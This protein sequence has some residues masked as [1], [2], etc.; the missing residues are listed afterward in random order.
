MALMKSAAFRPGTSTTLDCKTNMLIQIGSMCVR[1]SASFAYPRLY[2]LHTLG[3]GAGEMDPHSGVVA[4][5]APVRLSGDQI[6]P[7]GLYMLCLL[8]TSDAADDLLC[9]DVRGSRLI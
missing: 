2:A 3:P 9:V 7:E 5:P 4:M 6:T 1:Q 8:Y